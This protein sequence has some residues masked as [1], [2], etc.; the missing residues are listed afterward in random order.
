[1]IDRGLIKRVPGPGRAIRHRIAVKG[2]DLLE[3]GSHIVD[4]V[5]TATL[6]T[7]TPRQL[8]TL[9]QLLQHVLD[10]KPSAEK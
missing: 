6:G 4:N 2:Y 1:M 8:D 3:K 5:F 7:L 10:A 9:G